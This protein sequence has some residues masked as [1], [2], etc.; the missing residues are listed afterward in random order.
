MQ[1]RLR[2]AIEPVPRGRETGELLRKPVETSV[3]RYQ[4][5]WTNPPRPDWATPEPS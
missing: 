4:G 5:L 1:P 3:L 2:S